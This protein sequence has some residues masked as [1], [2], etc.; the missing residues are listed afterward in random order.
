MQLLVDCI[1][2]IC[3][4]HLRPAKKNGFRSLST[5]LAAFSARVDDCQPFWSA[6]KEID[7]HCL[8]LEPTSYCPTATYRRIA[9]D[10]AAT[11]SLLIDVDP[12]KP[13]DLPEARFLGRAVIER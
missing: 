7:D 6:M 11:V 1:F 3:T 10:Q 2:G 13:A 12:L 8:V 9:I 4:V 5:L